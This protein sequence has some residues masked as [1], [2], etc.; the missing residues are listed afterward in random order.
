MTSNQPTPTNNTE[1][2]ASSEPDVPMAALEEG[3]RALL[4]KIPQDRATK[5]D[6]EVVAE[7]V[8]ETELSEVNDLISMLRLSQQTRAEKREDEPEWYR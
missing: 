5:T 6:T 3:M 7:M 8:K 4:S 1:Q 2:L